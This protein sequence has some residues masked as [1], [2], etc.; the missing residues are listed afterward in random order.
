M[1]EHRYLVLIYF[2]GLI[3]SSD[4]ML[5]FYDLKNINFTNLIQFLP[6]LGES[7]EWKSTSSRISSLSS[8]EIL[9]RRSWAAL[10]DLST[11]RE[12]DR[13]ISKQRR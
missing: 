6:Y 1:P 9:R 7:G 11:Q 12:L 2:Q 5:Q 10:E 8:G 4:T 3:L 13:K